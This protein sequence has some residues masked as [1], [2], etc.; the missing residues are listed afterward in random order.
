MDNEVYQRTLDTLC[1][2]QQYSKYHEIFRKLEFND[3]MVYDKYLFVSPPIPGI[4]YNNNDTAKNIFSMTYNGLYNEKYNI[5]PY[6]SSEEESDPKDTF[7][8]N[9][10]GDFEDFARQNS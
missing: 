7:D 9:L 10:V 4:N 2:N 5:D 1:R 8:D 3:P 6:A